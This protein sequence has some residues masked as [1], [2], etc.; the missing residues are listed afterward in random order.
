MTCYSF[1][2]NV[3]IEGRKL[4]IIHLWL[5]NLQ[6][7]SILNGKVDVLQHYI[8]AFLVCAVKR[9]EP[10]HAVV[11]NLESTYICQ[12]AERLGSQGINQKVVGSIPGHA[13]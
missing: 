9:Q 5:L 7:F 8:D 12:M 11:I 10:Y 6:I 1:I 3:H 13:K 2:Q 4:C